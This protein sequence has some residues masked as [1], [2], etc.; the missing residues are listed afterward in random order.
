MIWKLPVSSK[1]QITIPRAIRQELGITGKR[2]TVILRK[3]NTGISIESTSQNINA[4]FGMLKPYT[5]KPPAEDMD[6]IIATAKRLQAKKR[7]K[8]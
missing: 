8:K 4:L 3:K 1:G 2:A 7:A 6:M 5:T